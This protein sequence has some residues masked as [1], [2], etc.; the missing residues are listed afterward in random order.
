MRDNTCGRAQH[1]SLVLQRRHSQP[2]RPPITIAGSLSSA[3]YSAEVSLS[4]EEG[5]TQEW[6]KAALQT[7][8]HVQ[9]AAER[10]VLRQLPRVYGAILIALKQTFHSFNIWFICRNSHKIIFLIPPKLMGS[11]VG[12]DLVPYLAAALRRE[13]QQLRRRLL[14]GSSVAGQRRGGPG[15]QRVRALG[16]AARRRRQ[17][18]SR[19]ALGLLGALRYEADLFGTQLQMAT[20]GK[21]TGRRTLSV[22]L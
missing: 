18:C 19:A 14:V 6:Q 10:I 20:R 2:R 4:D 16:H 1:D 22:P 7:R 21:D 5:P 11:K 12:L 17:P 3:W 9:Q 8:L 13:A 15:A